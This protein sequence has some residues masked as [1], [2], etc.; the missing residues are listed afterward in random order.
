MN[1]R[2]ERFMTETDPRAELAP[3]DVVSGAIQQQ[4]AAPDASGS[5]WIFGIWSAAA[6]IVIS[7]SLCAR[8]TGRRWASGGKTHGP[9]RSATSF[10]GLLPLRHLDTKLPTHEPPQVS[11]FLD[12]HPER[13]ALPVP[14]FALCA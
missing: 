5:F 8:A 1:G 7:A 9:P 4:P 12:P 6:M 13:L 2:G 14:G 3:R 11:T 10:P